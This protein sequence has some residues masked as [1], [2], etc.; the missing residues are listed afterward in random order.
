[1]KNSQKIPEEADF[2]C[3]LHKARFALLAFFLLDVAKP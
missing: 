3:G 2:V 1:M